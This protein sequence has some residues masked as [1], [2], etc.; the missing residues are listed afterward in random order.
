M[1]V[2]LDYEEGDSYVKEA[3]AQAGAKPN[4]SVRRRSNRRFPVT[5]SSRRLYRGSA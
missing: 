1:I 2:W 3:V 4:T 5:A